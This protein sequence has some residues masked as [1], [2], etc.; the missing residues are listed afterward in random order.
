MLLECPD[1]FPQRTLSRFVPAK[2][3]FRKSE[4]TE[5]SWRERTTFLPV[6]AALHKAARAIQIL[7]FY[8]AFGLLPLAACT[9]AAILFATLGVS[10]REPNGGGAY[11]LY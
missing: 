7:A 2:K 3:L 6:G 5:R 4:P 1:L 10:S 9:R 11:G 8:F